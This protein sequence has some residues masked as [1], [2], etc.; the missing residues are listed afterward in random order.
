MVYS[1]LKKKKVCSVNN[2]SLGLVTFNMLQR[3]STDASFMPSR[4]RKVKT[5]QEITGVRSHSSRLTPPKDTRRM[6][7]LVMSYKIQREDVRNWSVGQATKRE[8]ML[9]LSRHH[10]LLQ[11]FK[12]R[13]KALMAEFSNL[14]M[15]R[16][17]M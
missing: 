9:S 11:N 10:P 15:T 13:K 6:L 8:M 17:G 4:A 16:I 14:S 2:I 1:S 5:K 3:V 12:S 7:H